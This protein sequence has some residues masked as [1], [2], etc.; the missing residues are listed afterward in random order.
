MSKMDSGD[1]SVTNET[2]TSVIVMQGTVNHL[3]HTKQME[4]LNKLM[5]GTWDR[6][7]MDVNEDKDAMEQT[8]DEITY[9][10]AIT[11]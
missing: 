8:G 1:N 3:L 2:E 5:S 11:Q 7:T 9:Y 10:K 4:Y 6:K